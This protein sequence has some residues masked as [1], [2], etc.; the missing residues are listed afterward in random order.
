MR[1]TIRVKTFFIFVAICLVIITSMLFLTVASF[2]I[3]LSGYVGEVEDKRVETLSKRLSGLYARNEN[4]EFLK[5][6]LPLTLS[7]EELLWSD[8]L[9]PEMDDYEPLFFILS[10]DRSPVFGFYDPE[11]PAKLTPI[12][13]EGETIGWLG[14]YDDFFD[15]EV[16][17]NFLEN[18]IEMLWLIALFVT[19]LAI[20][21]AFTT[22]KHFQRSIQVLVTGTQSLTSGDYTIRI[23]V[24]TKDE[25]GDLTQD[26]NRLAETLEKN[27]TSRTQW[28][29]DISHELKTPLTLMSG[30]LEAIQDGIRQWDNKTADLLT[31]DISRL[32]FLVEDLKQLWL[33]ETNSL[34]YSLTPVNLSEVLQQTIDRFQDK[35]N[36]HPLTLTQIQ[37]D[38]IWIKGDR[39]RLGQVFDNLFKNSL[40]YTRAPGQLQVRLTRVDNK[41]R[42][43]FRD[44]APSV[45]EQNMDKI[46][47]RLY[48][49]EPSRNRKFGGAGIGLAIC[50]NIVQSH[51]GTI[52]AE[53]SPLGGLWIQLQFPLMTK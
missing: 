20:L 2:E 11:L 39:Y 14:I 30:E 26:F 25:L 49:V 15:A 53:M 13:Q 7:L 38:N 3:G 17:G 36:S 50:R 21:A 24:T 10:P 5:N 16:Y 29:E 22:A 8:E 4:F 6:N 31:N 9:L 23:P 52:S 27:E 18:Q 43:D 32:N 45:P 41:V 19:L 34:S 42:V 44:S 46:F 33:S 12:T 28:V 1:L 37:E 35:L 51:G 40:S 47:E 48:R